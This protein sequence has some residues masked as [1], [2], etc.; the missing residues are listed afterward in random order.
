MAR[1]AARTWQL[2]H[3]AF[4]VPAL[5]NSW[6]LGESFQSLSQD[7]DFEYVPVDATIC[8]THA[9]ATSRKGGLKLPVLAARKAA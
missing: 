5:D 7:P 8:K 1:L 4:P 6:G 9:D 2:A 3:G